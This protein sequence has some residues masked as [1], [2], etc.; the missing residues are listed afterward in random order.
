MKLE[1]QRL[2]NGFAYIQFGGPW[3]DS[4]FGVEIAK[5]THWVASQ[6]ECMFDLLVECGSFSASGWKPQVYAQEEDQRVWFIRAW[7]ELLNRFFRAKG[8][9]RVSNVAVLVRKSFGDQARSGETE[10][11]ASL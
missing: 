8:R 3:M 11:Q 6:D 2:R 10:R 5:C 9:I 4:G 1:L 7:F